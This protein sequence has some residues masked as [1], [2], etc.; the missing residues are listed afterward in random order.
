MNQAVTLKRKTEPGDFADFRAAMLAIMQRISGAQWT[1]HNIHDPGITILEQL[2]YGLTDI[3]YRSEL[4]VQDYLVDVDGNI[5]LV[6]HGLYHPEAVYFNQPVTQIDKIKYL[7]DRLPELA[8]VR[9]APVCFE[10]HPTGYSDIVFTSLHVDVTR[11]VYQD[12]RRLTESIRNLGEGIRKIQTT[13]EQQCRMDCE[14]FLVE[15]ADPIEAAKQVFEVAQKYLLGA[16]LARYPEE[17]LLSGPRLI[18][19]EISDT[20]LAQTLTPR[21]LTG[22]Y[23][24]IVNTDVVDRISGLSFKTLS[25]EQTYAHQLPDHRVNALRLANFEESVSFFSGTRRV[26]LPNLV[27]GGQTLH[28]AKLS[29][30]PDREWV[31]LNWPRKSLADFT[32]VQHQFPNNYGINQYGVPAHESNQRKAQAKQLRGYLSMFDQLMADQLQ[33]ADQLKS[34]FSVDSKPQSDITAHPNLDPSLPMDSLRRSGWQQ[35]MKPHELTPYKDKNNKLD[36]LLAMNG[37]AESDLGYDDHSPYFDTKTRMGRNLQA[38]ADLL[39]QWHGLQEERSQG[40]NIRQ[41]SWGNQNISGVEKSLALKL[42]LPPIRRS[43]IYP[44][45]KAG[46]QF[47]QKKGFHFAESEVVEDNALATLFYQQIDV[48]DIQSQAENFVSVQKVAV[49]SDQ[50]DA[51]FRQLRPDLNLENNQE[52][53]LTYGCQLE[54]YFL[55]QLVDRKSVQLLLKTSP[56]ELDLGQSH[57]I[58]I[59]SYRALEDVNRVANHLCEYLV[60]LNIQCEGFHLLEHHLLL[61]VN[62]KGIPI[63]NANPNPQT[64]LGTES[65]QKNETGFYLNRATLALP[66]WSARFRNEE[67]QQHL[68]R[69]VLEMVPAHLHTDILWLGY[70]QMERFEVYFKNWC[71]LKASGRQFAKLNRIANALKGLL[72]EAHESDQ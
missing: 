39:D 57:W 69:R 22:L 62:N 58:Y 45:V 38:K 54:N 16:S 56:N 29:L 26:V 24:A 36:F 65:E 71:Q 3:A 51:I 35:A 53:I 20:D 64:D 27:L 66:N 11:D 15:D 72:E 1:D 49:D 43:V 12:I 10:G 61:P 8:F 7:L 31:Q 44:L 68:E 48:Q 41:P 5:P 2:S 13:K 40:F 59:G 46:F 28:D 17:K 9:I 19:G 18:N 60:D 67:F 4:P 21:T 55:A 25:P 63:L 50:S 70:Q 14:I 37:L 30:R 32:S 33:T 52:S 6:K 23:Q 42:G 47:W 34:T